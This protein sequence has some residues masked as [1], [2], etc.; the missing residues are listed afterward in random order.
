MD[1]TN[2]RLREFQDAYKQDFGEHISPE[3]EMLS[4]LVTFNELLL[5]PL[6]HNDNEQ[7]ACS[8]RGLEHYPQNSLA[9]WNRML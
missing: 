5:R 7:E 9:H 2:D 3:R 1:I 6:P 4:P 8:R